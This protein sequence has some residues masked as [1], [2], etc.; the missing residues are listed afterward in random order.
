M[1]AGQ[2]RFSPDSFAIP[3]PHDIAAEQA[4]LGAMMLSAAAAGSC[5]AALSDGDFYR[6]AHGVI[7]AAI[8]DMTRQGCAVDWLTVRD[9]LE[10]AGE[11]A[12]IAD[13]VLYLNTLIHSV[14][15]AAN[16]GYYARIVRDRAVRRRLLMAGRRIVQMGAEAEA[17]AHGLAERAM[18]EVE[19]VRDSDFGDGLTVQTVYEF[20]GTED[21]DEYDWVI[22]GLIERGDRMVLTGQEGAGKSEL[23]RMFA[24]C[25]AAGVHPFTAEPIPP[26]RVL[27]LDCENT[28]RHT[29]RKMRPLV[30]QARLQGYPVSEGNL[31]IECR[32]AGIDLA[33]DKDVSWLMRQVA[34]VQPA[35]T[36]LGPLYRLAPRALNDDSDAAPVLATLNMIRAR[37]SAVILEAHAGHA[38]GPGGRRDL[39]PRGSSAF[40]GW[41]EFGY[42]LR[43][44]DPEEDEQ[45]NEI[46]ERIVDL[47]G[48]RGDRDERDWPQ[49]LCAGGVWPWRTYQRPV[50]VKAPR[51]DQA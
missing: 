11:L 1:T 5:L 41:P 45:G 36:F 33:L 20:L 16:A 24:V 27:L 4:V 26:Q 10:A 29:R 23:F 18:R 2:G 9:A 6:P 47:V 3:D 40:L 17:D 21:A 37:G 32:P 31:W 30:A 34:T 50:K 35:I 15:S 28:G 14:P 39:R 48:W 43:W 42:G 12:R 19:A 49:M 38:M 25:V 8:R 44:A 46:P 7:F 22:P 51:W 13:G